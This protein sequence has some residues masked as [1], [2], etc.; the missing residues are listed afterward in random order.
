MIFFFLFSKCTSPKSWWREPHLQMDNKMVMV[1]SSKA[2]NN[3]ELLISMEGSSRISRFDINVEIFGEST[4]GIHRKPSWN[5]G[6][7]G[8]K[9]CLISMVTKKGSENQ[10]GAKRVHQFTGYYSSLSGLLFLSPIPPCILLNPWNPP[11]LCSLNSLSLISSGGQVLWIPNPQQH[12][13][14][15]DPSTLAMLL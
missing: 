3:I 2:G 4:G 12:L 9:T 11:G 1:I 15:P 5:F 13:Q 8:I 14:L 6:I 7:Y 10:K